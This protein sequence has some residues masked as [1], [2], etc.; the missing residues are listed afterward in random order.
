VGDPDEARRA[1]LRRGIRAIVRIRELAPKGPRWSRAWKRLL[2]RYEEA[3]TKEEP[4]VLAREFRP[5]R[6]FLGKLAPGEEMV[7]A[8]AEFCRDRGIQTGWVSAIGTMRRG[9]VGYFEQEERLYRRLAV[10]EPMEIVSCQ[11]NVSLRDGQPFVHLHV[12]L[13]GS[14]GRTVAGHLFEGIAFVG[15]FWVQEMI[16]TALERVP[17]ADSGLALW[18]L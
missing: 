11:G 10:E 14:D 7:S 9:V 18:D 6:A 16:G 17:D 15:E 4:M 2:W 5:G 12:V 8:L 1:R 3:L 13:S